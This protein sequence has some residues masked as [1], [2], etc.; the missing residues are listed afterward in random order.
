VA[1]RIL[2]AV[3]HVLRHDKAFKDLG[4]AYLLNMH[5]K[6]RLRYL[7]KQAAQL[8]YFLTPKVIMNIQ[9]SVSEIPFYGKLGKSPSRLLG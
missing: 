7:S 9:S 1:H 5:A 2:K 3:Y 8:G 4:E 6:S